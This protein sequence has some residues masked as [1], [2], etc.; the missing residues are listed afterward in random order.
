MTTDEKKKAIN[1]L[2][3]ILVKILADYEEL[4][5]KIKDP[6]YQ[7]AKPRYEYSELSEKILEET[8][9]LL[10]DISDFT[11]LREAYNRLIILCFSFNT[12]VIKAVSGRDF[13]IKPIAGNFLTRIT[14]EYAPIECGTILYITLNGS[15]IGNT[16]LQ[17]LDD[18]AEQIKKSVIHGLIVSKLKEFLNQGGMTQPG[19]EG[20]TP[21]REDKKKQIEALVKKLTP[22]PTRTLEELDETEI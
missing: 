18:C 10:N 9:Q 16:T 7:L 6:K 3:S 17:F 12:E 1:N 5:K 21:F 11:Q 15:Y 22:D 14:R 13:Q 8:Q 4:F 20:I 19:E 2:A